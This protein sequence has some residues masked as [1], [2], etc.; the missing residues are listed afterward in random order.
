MKSSGVAFADM[1]VAFWDF[2]I[3]WCGREEGGKGGGG[4][5]IS[6]PGKVLGHNGQT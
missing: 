4:G 1:S 5:F 6:A 2:G 3:K